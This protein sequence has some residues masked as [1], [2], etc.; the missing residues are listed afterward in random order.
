[1]A[2]TATG[3]LGP[4]LNPREVSLTF[5]CSLLLHGA[6]IA[7]A[8]WV[9]GVFFAPHVIT[10]PPSYTVNLVSSLPGGSSRPAPPPAAQRPA[11]PPA[12]SAPPAPTP[13]P[14]AVRPAP[15]PP[16]APAPSDDL[17]LPGR[18]AARK[19]APAPEA[20]LR[21]SAAPRTPNPPLTP[22]T[23]P[24]TKAAPA[25]PPVPIP[26]PAPSSA[27]PAPTVASVPPAAANGSKTSGPELAG[28]AGAGAGEGSTLAYY[29]TLVDRKIQENWNPVGTAPLPETVVVV[30]FRVQR[31]GQVRDLE[32]E[33][34]AGLRSLDE[35]ALRAVRQ[36]L[37][38]PP[39]PNLL[40]EPYLD[41]RYRFVMER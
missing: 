15:P 39:F 31:S 25:G 2:V 26:A 24:A 22:P 21:P 12:P 10:V 33:S 17:V 9:P 29:L 18:Q 28:S 34:G 11:P 38:L 4:R 30:R 20:S 14:A 6:L 5:A 36:S 40:A 23:P 27:P 37:P 1:M 32:L 8:L 35:A 41:L 3:L 13:P 7:A 19:A 16:P